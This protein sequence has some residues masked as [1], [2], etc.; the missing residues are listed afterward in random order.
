MAVLNAGKVRILTGGDGFGIYWVSVVELLVEEYQET[1]IYYQPM[2][3]WKSS[4]FEVFASYPF[5]K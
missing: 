5:R 1:R 4:F 3:K 2:C